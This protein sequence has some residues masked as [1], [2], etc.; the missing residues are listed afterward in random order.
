MVFDGASSVVILAL[1]SITSL[2]TYAS[3]EYIS[4]NSSAV[5]PRHLIVE[6]F[7]FVPF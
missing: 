3:V 4:R 6:S 7:V 2:P 5:Q 1:T